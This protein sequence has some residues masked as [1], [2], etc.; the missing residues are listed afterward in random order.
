MIGKLREVIAYKDE[1]NNDLYQYIFDL[2]GKE[3][4]D[5]S[6]EN[7]ECGLGILKN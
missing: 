1:K 6:T 4:Q 5:F 3:F 2:E 7:V